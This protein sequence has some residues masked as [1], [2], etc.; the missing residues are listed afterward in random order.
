MSRSIVDADL[1]C[2]NCNQETEHQIEYLSDK[3][4]SITCT[5]CGSAVHLD[6]SSMEKY[7]KEDVISRLVSKPGRMTR[8]MQ[9]DLN[10]FLKS[11]PLRVVTKPYR[12]IKELE[13]EENMRNAYR[14]K[15]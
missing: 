10:G 1:F 13:K 15:Q 4:Q 14:K 2:A 9:A 8:E 12:I 11:F 7:Y 3:I 5:K 6:V